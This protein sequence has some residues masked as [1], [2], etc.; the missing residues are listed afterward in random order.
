MIPTITTALDWHSPEIDYLEHGKNGI[1]T[2]AD[3][4]AEEFGAT[5]ADVL[6][7]GPRL[8]SLCEGAR[9]AGRRL[10]IEDMAQRF[11]DGVE[12]ALAAPPR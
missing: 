4:S 9:S 11:A 10:S 3:V 1:M 2:A 7:D 12:R 6:S 8:K 5:V